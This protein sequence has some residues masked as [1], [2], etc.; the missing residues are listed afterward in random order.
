MPNLKKHVTVGAAVGGG[1]NLAWQLC[2]IFE[3]PNPPKGFW[4]TVERIDFLELALF[5][6]G[7]AAVAALPDVIEPA[8]NPNHRAMFH[9]LAC[10]G[11]LTYGAFGKHTHK[12]LPEN[13]HALQ[14]AALS[15]L[16]H[17]LLD[18]G[19]PKSLPL[20]GLPVID[21]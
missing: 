10:A 17:L 8:D 5:A 15:Y 6:L 18:S 21:I 1:A 9:S 13:R 12:M 19:T 11:V 7:G 2:N 3:S 4:Q 16:S 20:A 14:V